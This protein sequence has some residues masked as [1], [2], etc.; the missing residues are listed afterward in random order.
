MAAAPGPQRLAPAI[1]RL[2]SPGLGYLK[3]VDKPPVISS[4][5]KM[6][7]R[8]EHLLS[9]IIIATLSDLQK[10]LLDFTS[11]GYRQTRR[12]VPNI[13]YIYFI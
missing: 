5:S 2:D 10:I 7:S 1:F 11:E 8:R 13:I 6:L 4:D 12:L 9:P 3:A